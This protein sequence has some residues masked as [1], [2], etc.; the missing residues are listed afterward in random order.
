M[1]LPPLARAG[2][3][4]TDPVRASNE[5]FLTRHRRDIQ[6]LRAV[7]VLLV[8][9][10]H[11]SV[12][13]LKGGYIGVDV[14]F[15]LSGY[16]I[17]GI[18]LVNAERRGGVSLLDFYVRR[19]RRILPAATLTLVSTAVAS[20]FLLN[21]VRAQQA[22]T[23]IVWAAFF[24]ANFRDTSTATNYFAQGQPPSPVQHF[25]SLAVEEQFY[26]V[27]PT[28]LAVVVFGWGLVRVARHRGVPRL[29]VT[30]RGMLRLL[31]AIGLVVAA[32]LAWSI[33]Q[34]HSQP[35]VAYF[36][37]F[38][39]AWELGIG[40]GLAI[41]ARRLD[42]LPKPIRLLMGWGGLGMILGGAVLFSPSTP[43]PGA[44][45]L[46]PTLGA[47]LVIAAGIAS[48]ESRWS[49]S[50]VLGV[51]P[52]RYVGD[53][54][55]TLYLWHWPVIVL[56][57]ERYGPL[58]VGTKLLL[59]LG[60]FV[61]S[62]VTYR[63][64]EN[65]LRRGERWQPTG[66]A[67]RALW[68]C[69]PV[70]VLLVVAVYQGKIDGQVS[71]AVAAS[72]QQST[73][74][75]GAGLTP[76]AAAQ[77]Q[78]DLATINRAV[79]TQAPLPIVLAAAKA[80]DRGAPLPAGLVPS[81]AAG[82]LTGDI[83]NVPSGCSLQPGAA[84]TSSRICR[85][86]DTS[87]SRTMVVFG[88]SHAQMWMGTILNMAARDGW[89][90]VPLMKSDCT[91]WMGGGYTPSPGCTSWFRWAVQKDRSLHPDVTL[92][93]SFYQY[94]THT[95]G[96]FG[97]LT[98]ELA[99]L[100]NTFRADSQKVLIMGD[101]FGQVA[102]PSDCLLSANATMRTCSSPYDQSP[103]TANAEVQDLAGKAGA[104]F[105]STEGWFCALDRCPM[106]V[107]NTV[108]YFDRSHVTQQYASEMSVPFRDAFLRAARAAKRG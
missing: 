45:A 103:I 42:Q 7:A 27:W 100:I 14:F 64:Y 95:P 31:V 63:V 13:F 3:R 81:P 20:Y 58:S 55:Y 53:R 41:V 73:P 65:P 98:K 5:Q 74:G 36:S 80:G 23:D 83:Y 52:M 67:G 34:T 4:A 18:L 22:L 59:V 93:S 17:T 38:T 79:R 92:I 85:L 90:V 82:Q 99:V 37:T 76:G 96:Y 26:V 51:A 75:L 32:S 101:V 48:H 72:Y 88:D 77:T 84:Q 61:L 89:T 44:A 60:A 12:G 25:W 54:S 87:A 33:H 66:A 6:G 43:F 68:F 70:A 57:N 30:E 78:H 104:G 102:N 105:I 2:V 28:V 11:A 49:A 94:P 15:V 19:A 39:R 106:V 29:R 24:A 9:L 47:G 8:A 21:I 56:I 46:L 86:G 35:T 107:G 97:T 69:T 71:A 40:A 91:V 50:R 16:L 10:N 1:R 62:V 108:V